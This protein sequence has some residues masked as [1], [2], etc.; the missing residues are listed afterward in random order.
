M[1]HQRS[2]LDR[3]EITDIVWGKKSQRPTEAPPSDLSK[4]LTRD[5]LRTRDGQPI[6]ELG[7]NR[8]PIQRPM[9]ASAPTIL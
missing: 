1:T 3:V 7:A 9:I 6:I 4:D 8:Q 2:P 5:V